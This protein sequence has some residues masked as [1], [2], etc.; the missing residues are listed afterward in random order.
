MSRPVRDWAGTRPIPA[1]AVR[2]AECLMPRRDVACRFCGPIAVATLVLALGGAALAVVNHNGPAVGGV[3]T[4]HLTGQFVLA[5]MYT[6]GGW[7]LAKYRPRVIYGWLALAAG[8]GHA[9]AVTGIGWATY[10]VTDGRHL[11]GADAA[12]LGAFAG[13]P[14]ENL[15]VV[16]FL[17]TF[18]YGRLPVGRLRWL[19][20]TAG[21]LCGGGW[22]LG[23]LAPV[24]ET[25]DLPGLRNPI[26]VLPGLPFELLYATGLLLASIVIIRRW[27]KAEDR[28][29]QVLRWL[30]VV[31]LGAIALTPAIV[32]LPMGDLITTVAVAIELLVIAAVVL[33]HQLYGI[34]KVLNRA[35]VYTL[36]LGVVTAVYGAGIAVV[37]LL[38]HRAGGP[39][40]Y[41]AALA[42]AFSLAPARSRL[43]RLVNQF[44]YGRRD[45]PFT[46][47]SRIASSLET[48]GSVAELL[49]RLVEAIA[50]ELRLPW[51]AVELCLDDGSVREIVHER[52]APRGVIVRFPLEQGEVGA[53]VVALRSGQTALGAEEE[54]LMRSIA[55]QVGVAASNVLLTEELM[56]SRDQILTATE[57]ERRRLR[58]DLHDGLGP[59]LTAAAT[60]VDAATNLL[61]RNPSQA[62]AALDSVRDDLGSALEDLRR[63][64]YALRPPVLDQLG[65]LGSLRQHLPHLSVPIT[66]TAPETLPELPP[67][68]E[69]AAYRIVTEAVTNV[70]RHARATAC[71]VRVAC[72]DK[73]I[74]EV[75]DDGR[76]GDPWQPGV[77]LTSMRERVT[78]LGGNWSAG[79]TSAGGRVAVELPLTL[80]GA[81]A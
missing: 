64:V 50:T 33:S 80:T 26:G 41:L 7:L 34:E 30:A 18:P 63:L 6:A 32:L 48:S 36:S 3:T 43:Q 12:L 15:A 49:P 39:W 16:A 58:R 8:L 74:L 75:H 1:S 51:V 52:N 72:S 71:T 28:E 60:K 42:A 29:R 14:L 31:N 47:V 55:A 10:T 61:A 62:V 5:V 17:V 25:P 57:N 67:A 53:L 56:R 40:A 77:G 44:L 65:L 79:P 76:G 9:M 70:C 19:A 24:P 73:L 38:G 59:T 68:V 13:E 81:T 66:L 27:R 2:R 21:V 69:I 11:P 22:L 37:A 4:A 45:E 46:V 23:L 35:L 78:A 54:R 20:I